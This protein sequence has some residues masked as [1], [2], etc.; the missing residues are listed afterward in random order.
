[1]RQFQ[2]GKD[3]KLSYPLRDFVFSKGMFG[4]A[5]VEKSTVERLLRLND[6][7]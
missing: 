4:V 3:M 6:T 2:I 7:K 5:Y 1:M